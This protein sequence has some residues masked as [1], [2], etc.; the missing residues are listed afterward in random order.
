MKSPVFFK[1]ALVVAVG[2][3][4]TLMP[5]HAQTAAPQPS[6]PAVQANGSAPVIQAPNILITPKVGSD[7]E[8]GSTEPRVMRGTDKLLNIDPS[9]P[10]TGG[11]PVSFRFEEAPVA[12][13]VRTV[14]GDILKIDYVMHPPLQGTVTLTTPKPI[15]P[16]K[17]VFLLEAALQANGLAMVRDARGT[18]QVGKPEVLRSLVGN[19]RMAGAPGSMAPGY[20]VIVVPLQYIGA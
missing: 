9:A 16:D 8:E 5:L 13:V 19:V 3:M 20:G 1:T 17:A 7:E 14:M 10:V 4:G 18:Y 2:Q 6:V 15:D 12:E 11:A